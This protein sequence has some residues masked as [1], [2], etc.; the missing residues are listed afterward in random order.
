MKR[1]SSYI[2]ALL[3]AVALFFS[4][5]KKS[6]RIIPEN[7]LAGIYVDMLVLDEW[8]K[9][10]ALSRVADTSVVYEPIFNR[11]G[12]TT[13]DYLASVDHYLNDPVKF[14]KI[15]KKV[16][17]II[18]DHVE[19]IGREEILKQKADSAKARFES[20][21]FRRLEPYSRFFEELYSQDTINLVLDEYGSYTIGDA[22]P[23]T[24]FSG[25]LLV[26]RDTVGAKPPV[27][28]SVAVEK[29]DAEQPVVVERPSKTVEGG[30][31]L[32]QLQPMQMQI[33]KR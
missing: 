11:H 23:D 28:D 12:Y 14:A 18:T 5:E 7:K 1:L 15:F 17:T 9:L 10:E 32:Q 21:K 22:T 6:G 33:E 2:L 26:L 25:P 3:A 20:L 13:E 30:R 4:C 31:K 16:E 29:Q 19:E 24:L 8:I 27:K